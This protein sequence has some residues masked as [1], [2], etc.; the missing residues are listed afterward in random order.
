MQMNCKP[1]PWLTDKC[2]KWTKQITFISFLVKLWT[3]KVYMKWLND[4]NK[5]AYMYYQFYT[6]R[7]THNHSTRSIHIHLL[8]KNLLNVDITIMFRE[9]SKWPV[10]KQERDYGTGGIHP[11]GNWCLSCLWSWSRA[12][13]CT[14][15]L[16]G[17]IH[18]SR[19]GRRGLVCKDKCSQL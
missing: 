17:Y 1:I 18:L 14:R 2:D 3:Y 5:L 4:G 7:T 10:A 6:T 9:V 13:A 15:G 19:N 16:W 11:T 12:Y 8:I